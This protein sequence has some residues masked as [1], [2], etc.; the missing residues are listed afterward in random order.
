MSI[1][2]DICPQICIFAFVIQYETDYIMFYV[3]KYT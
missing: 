1:T 3:D 2:V